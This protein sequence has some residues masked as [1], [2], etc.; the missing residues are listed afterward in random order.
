MSKSPLKFTLVLTMILL[1]FAFIP[2]PP[3]AAHAILARSEPADNAILSEPPNQ[4]RLW[5][6]EPISP[7]FSTAQLLDVTGTAVPLRGI[8]TVP[9]EPNLLILDLPPLE[10]GVYSV[11]WKVLSQS[12]GHFTQGLIVFG[13]GT[14]ADLNQAQATIPKT[15]VPWPEVALRWANFTIL[16]LL[17]G[18]LTILAFLLTPPVSPPTIVT[19]YQQ[20]RQRAWRLAY[21]CAISGLGLGIGW[22]M[23]QTAV[24]RPEL[25]PTTP[26]WTI[27]SQWLTQSRPGLLWI[28]RQTIWLAFILS[29]WRINRNH[30]PSPSSPLP[31][32]LLLLTFPLILTQSLVSHAAALTTNTTLA[33]ITDSLHLLAAALWIGSLLALLMTLLPPARQNKN[34]L[35]SLLQSGW[36]PFGRLAALSIGI[37]AATGLYSLGQQ[38]ATPD[39]LL[40]TNYGRSLFL[41]TLLLLLTLSFGALN[42]ILLHP[43]LAAIPARLLRRP[44]GWTPLSWRW[45]PRLM[46]IEATLGLGVILLTAY[47]TAAPNASQAPTPPEEIPTTATQLVDDMLITLSIKPNRPGAN[48][49]NIRAVSTRR[50]APAEVL[51][52]IVRFTYLEQDL[53][54]ESVVAEATNEPGLYRLGGNQLRLPGRWQIDVVV[55]RMGIADAVARY[56]WTL[57]EAQSSDQPL[58]SNKQWAPWLTIGAMLML[59]ATLAGTAV[60][61]WHNH[62]QPVSHL[63]Q[64]T[65]KIPPDFSDW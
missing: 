41:K 27:A 43:T 1:L 26:I 17:I 14:T 24:L 4:V 59:L 20:A 55:R 57:P 56:E 30:L 6:T 53:G 10:E 8:R 13:I 21:M 19:T 5:L 11:W 35:R 28:A 54:I 16:L 44:Q 40:L 29:L 32:L 3:V 36:Q 65:V 31:H 62:Q 22:I 39:A 23:W 38:V 64:Q 50:P 25:P 49:M 60:Y 18:S 51:R 42:A 58:I 45:L 34:H 52:V 12:D 61:V 15:A 46:L 48:V 47:L 2:T 63:A 7:E 37:L 9:N 33:I